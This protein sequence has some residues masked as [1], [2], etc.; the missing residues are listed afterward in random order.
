[1]CLIK[2]VFME[3]LYKL[4]NNTRTIEKM[5]MYLPKVGIIYSEDKISFEF[6]IKFVP[7]NDAL[8]AEADDELNPDNNLDGDDCRCIN[9]RLGT[10]ESEENR[11]LDDADEVIL[12]AV[13]LLETTCCDWFGRLSSVSSIDAV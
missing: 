4:N 7:F 10:S 3:K 9:V 6:G 2:S 13:S 8:L 5:V 11:L 12:E 1:M